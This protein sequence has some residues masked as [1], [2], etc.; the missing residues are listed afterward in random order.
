MPPYQNFLIQHLSAHSRR[1]CLIANSVLRTSSAISSYTTRV[2]RITVKY[3]TVDSIYVQYAGFQTMTEDRTLN[4]ITLQDIMSQTN[5][6][7]KYCLLITYATLI[8]AIIVTDH[9]IFKILPKFFY[10]KNF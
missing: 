9:L 6:G 10:V 7:L 3:I 8:F 4:T 5:G 1:I 2:R